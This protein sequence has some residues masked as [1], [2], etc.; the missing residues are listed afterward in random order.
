[1]LRAREQPLRTLLLATAA[2][3]VFD[4]PNA[5][6]QAYPTKPIRVVVGAAPG[7]NT[8]FFFRAV[9]PSMSATLGHQLVPDYRVGGGGVVGAA[10]TA[11]A[12][13]DGYVIGITSSGFVIYPALVK[14]L[15]FDPLRDFTPL[16]HVVN[17]PQALVIHPSLP[18]K[19]VKELIAFARARPGQLNCGNAGVGTNAHLAAVLF[20]QVARVDIVHISYKSTPPVMMDLLTGEIHMTFPSISG[21]LGHARSGRMRML[22]QTGKARSATVAEV[23]TMQEAGL[24]GFAMESRFGLVGPANLP[25]PIA[26]KLNAALVKAVQ[27]PATRKLLLD[28]GADPLGSTPQDQMAFTKAEIER[29]LEVT[30]KAG[31]KPE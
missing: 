17:V 3:I 26:E 14:N 21:V 6:A 7:S 31:M 8:D 10:T 5:A 29:W 27:D 12:A 23:P 16:G 11:K 28:S 4:A 25:Q 19:T 30:K 20:N 2:C 22:A 15:A 9:A 18:A 13:P 1:M 24:P